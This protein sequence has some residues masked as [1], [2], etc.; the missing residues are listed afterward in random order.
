MDEVIATSL[1]L[2]P[3]HLGTPAQ[4][5][6]HMHVQYITEHYKTVTQ[7]LAMKTKIH[8]ES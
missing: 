7:T 4:H 3:S 2:T 8:W 6:A 1:L 5:T